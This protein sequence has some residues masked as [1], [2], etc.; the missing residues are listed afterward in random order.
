MAISIGQHSQRQLRSL[1]CEALGW[2]PDLY[3]GL[4]QAALP[5]L[6]TTG[7]PRRENPRFSAAV[8]VPR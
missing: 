1:D 2:H 6:Y 5:H 8:G 7:A 4:V 3:L